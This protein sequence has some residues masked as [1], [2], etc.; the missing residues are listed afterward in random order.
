MEFL[1]KKTKMLERKVD[2]YLD[3]ISQGS[4]VFTQSMRYYMEGKSLEFQDKYRTLS[5]MEHDADELRREIEAQ[6]YME[7]LIPD[8]RGDV[9][10][11]LENMDNVIDSAKRTI[12]QF[13]VENPVIPDFAQSDFS[14]LGEACTKAV[15][16]L[17]MAARAFF[18]DINA[19]KDHIHK[20]SFY[21]GEADKIADR[22]KRKIFK[23]DLDL[24]H[25]NHLRFFIN[26]VESLSDHAEEVAER[27]SI[28]TIKRTI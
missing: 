28:Y 22:M 19:V 8:S 3:L 25:K 4:I 26:N 20:V 10:G 13:D 18:R 15:E 2:Q 12:A 5:T 23:S 17:V 27:L 9:L 7:S 14:E 21:E 16:A 11:I 1:F 6:L 24:A